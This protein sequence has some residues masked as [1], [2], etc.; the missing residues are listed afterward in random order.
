MGRWI[1][2]V[3]A[4]LAM[5][6]GGALALA[7]EILP[8]KPPVP[9]LVEPAWSLTGSCEALDFD[10]IDI[11]WYG[12]RGTYVLTVGGMKPYTN[13]EVSLSHKGYGSR[14]AYWQTVVVGCVKNFLVMP[15][16]SPYYV[17]MPLDR[18]VGTRGVEIIGASRTVRRNVPRPR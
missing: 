18:F 3:I 4:G 12:G 17:T 9:R 14:P 16:P 15:I 10:N 1:G 11:K 6:G 2:C 13:M 8:D 5:L 7:S